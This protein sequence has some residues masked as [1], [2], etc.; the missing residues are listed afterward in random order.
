MTQG[1]YFDP[2]TLSNA[3]STD[4]ILPGHT[5]YLR[6]GIYN[7]GSGKGE[8]DCLLQ[9]SAE[10]QITI[11]PLPGERVRING[12]LNMLMNICQYVTLR[13]V[14][15]A[16]T[17]TTRAFATTEEIDF[18]RGLNF[19]GIG[20]K[21]WN[22]IIHDAQ[23]GVGWFGSGVG[24]VYGCLFYNNGWDVGGERD[25]AIYSHNHAGGR[26]DLKHN[27]FCKQF[28]GYGFHGFSGGNRVQDYYLDANIFI[29][30]SAIFNS[31]VQ[32]R[33]LHYLNNVVFN[34]Q[35][36]AGASDSGVNEDVEFVGNYFDC[37][38][39]D[40]AGCLYHPTVSFTGNT[41]VRRSGA[42]YQCA[43]YAEPA[44]GMT[45]LVWNNNAYYHNVGEHLHPLQKNLTEYFFPDWQGLGLDADSTYTRDLPTTNIVRVFPNAYI[46]I[47]DPRVGIVVIHNHEG[48]NNVDVDLSALN[49]TNGVQYK[50]MQVQ[51]PYVDTIMFT[52]NG[53]PVSVDMQAGS[54][55]VA[56]PTAYSDALSA[57]TFPQFGCFVLEK[58]G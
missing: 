21:L 20:N 44:S 35:F 43:S 5:L 9:G 40:A 33:N 8:L 54:H 58:I 34:G 49:L 6:G 1:N 16:P 46:D 51:N 56:V 14:E 10:S 36:R 15:I 27:I 25:Y 7:I 13:N 32:A 11:R 50:L 41:I 24:E 22:C 19:T 18:P 23:Q 57:T 31:G 38:S 55:S 39:T 48:L 3:L 47:D 12:G 2:F 29:E 30:S 53:N 45:S 42:G 17:P 37:Y 52:Y 4:R 28:G 26:R